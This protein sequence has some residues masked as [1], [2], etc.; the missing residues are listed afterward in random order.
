MI[1]AIKN[2]KNIY[3]ICGGILK[4]KNLNS[5][6]PYTHKIKKVYITGVKKNQFINFFFSKKN[7]IFVSSNLN[8]IVKE[9]FKDVNAREESTILFCPG[10]ASFDQFKNFEERGNKFKKIVLGNSKK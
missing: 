4:D 5:L 10:A 6:T 9:C 1:K 7:K 3:L 2:Y 8:K